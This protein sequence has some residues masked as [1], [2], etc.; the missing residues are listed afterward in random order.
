[1]SAVVIASITQ[2]CEPDHH[3][4]PVRLE[5]WLANKSPEGLR[6]MLLAGIRTLF[7]AE[8]DGVVAAVGGISGDSVVLNYVAPQYRFMGISRALMGALEASL[9]AQG[10]RTIRLMSSATAHRFYLE[11]GWQDLSQPGIDYTHTGRPMS[12]TLVR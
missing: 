7:V 12:K 5:P 4:D 2:L 3:N 10:H 6:T 1:M 11:L 9:E 8:V